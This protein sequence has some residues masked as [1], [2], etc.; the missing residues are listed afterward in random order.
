[1]PL[2]LKP[3]LAAVLAASLLVG[4]GFVAGLAYEGRF[5]PAEPAKH[6]S[7][8]SQGDRTG[9]DVLLTEEQVF[10]RAFTYE[11]AIRGEDPMDPAL[12]LPLPAADLRDLATAGE[13]ERIRVR[14]R[15]VYLKRVITRQ[16]AAAIRKECG[17]GRKIDPAHTEQLEVIEGLQ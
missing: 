2:G 12:L 8:T 5:S 11:E 4:V 15:V 9:V 16:D 7:E 14:E 17:T 10:G 1:M 13:C 6:P 3:K